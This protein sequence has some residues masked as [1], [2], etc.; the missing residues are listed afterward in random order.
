MRSQS[1]SQN[2]NRKTPKGK[3]AWKKWTAPAVL[4]AGFS[5]ES[6]T[7]RQIAD[8]IEGGGQKHAGRCRFVTAS[9]I[10][11]GQND[12]LARVQQAGSEGAN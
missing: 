6:A 5:S 10:L 4:R 9:A 3:G 12:G 1:Q 11:E 8:S 2:L 7:A